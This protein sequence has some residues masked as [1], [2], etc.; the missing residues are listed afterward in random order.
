MKQPTEDQALSKTQKNFLIDE[1]LAQLVDRVLERSGMN[2]TKFATAAILQSLFHRFSEPEI[3]TVVGPDPM[4][5]TIASQLERGAFTLGDVPERL[6]KDAVYL[7]KSNID[8]PEHHRDGDKPGWLEIQKR[9]QRDRERAAKHWVESIE[10]SG[11]T[12]E[13]ALASIDE[14]FPGK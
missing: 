11:G 14:C 2:F 4:W 5:T 1:Q 9:T 13:A 7:V 8:D 12:F 10:E 3:S 6:M